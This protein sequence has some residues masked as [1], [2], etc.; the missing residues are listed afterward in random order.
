VLRA[1][2]VRAELSFADDILDIADDGTNDWA[3]TVKGRTVPNKELVLRSKLRIEARR[4]HMER[5][6]RDTWGEK[7]QSETNINFNLLSKEELM[8]K[9]RELLGMIEFL[10]APPPVPPPIEYRH[11]EAPD[12]EEPQGGIGR[13]P[14]PVTGPEG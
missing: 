2:D 12:D 3:K 10:K 7:P 5:L 6:H 4:F 13:Q 9:A 11:E 1:R 14:R 8:A